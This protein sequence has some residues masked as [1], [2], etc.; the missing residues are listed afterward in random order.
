MKMPC[1]L[2]PFIRIIVP[3]LLVIIA[4]CFWIHAEIRFY[5]TK[6]EQ[7]WMNY[8]Y[9]KIIEFQKENQSHKTLEKDEWDG[10]R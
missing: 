3:I 2:N 9:E 1:S 5:E 4:L 6:V 10:Y 7:K 8:Y